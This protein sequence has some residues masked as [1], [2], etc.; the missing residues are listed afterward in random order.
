MKVIDVNFNGPIY[1]ARIASVYLRQSPG[2]DTSKP[3]D[4]SLT[5]V[6]SV[7]GIL[8]SPDLF[9]YSASKHGVIGLMRSLRKLVLHFFF[10][11]INHALVHIARNIIYSS[12]LTKPPVKILPNLR[13]TDPHK[14]HLPLDDQDP[15]RERH[16]REMGG[17]RTSYQYTH[18]CSQ[19]NSRHASTLL[20]CLMGLWILYSVTMLTLPRCSRHAYS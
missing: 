1:F 8:E 2:S 5:L 10:I 15:A 7:A 4:R 19:G 13:P 18:G 3:T 17:A 9:V 16:R 6:S 12:S 11:Y 20:E 14:L